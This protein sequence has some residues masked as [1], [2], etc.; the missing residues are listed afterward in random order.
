MSVSDQTPAKGALSGLRVLELGQLI[1]G[2]MA[3]A[4][5]G[6]YGAEVVKIEKPDGG[7]PIRSWRVIEDGT[8]VWW[9]HLARNKRLAAID[10][11]TEEG[12]ML[13]RELALVADV[14]IENFRPGTLEAWGLDPD[15][16]RAANPR[17]IVARVSGYGQTGPDR[18][19]RGFASVCEAMGGLRYVTGHPGEIPVRSNLSIGDSLAGFHTT[20]GILLALVRRER[21]AERRGQVVD[22]SIVE[23]VMSVMEG[24]I[25]EFDR[26][27]AVRQPSGTTITGVVPTGAYPCSDGR[28][29]VIG[30]NGDSM[31]RR[32]MRTMARDD[33]ADD[34]R[35]ATNDLRVVA[36][37]ELDEAI[38]AWT[39][40]LTCEDVVA[41]L[42]DAGVPAGAI[43]TAQDLAEDAHLA[44]RGTFEHVDVG[45]RPLK[46]AAPGPRLSE[47]PGRTTHAGR[48]LGADTDVVLRD[49]LAV[50]PA[51]LAA[52]REANVIA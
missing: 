19:R 42:Q 7:D 17:L 10:L 44:E 35:L 38:G 30:A 23:S 29:V 48:D 28:R 45:G 49:W 11:R 25:S 26:T 52:L 34:P 37:D 36:Q 32:L 13:V 4:L 1:A 39:S 2:P 46:L 8:S 15:D 9:R 47:T 41:R 6:W 40:T 18:E 51:R 14:L 24:A 50:E 31:F 21:D 22:V 33:L 3:G 16:L 43:R 20:M 12:R 5:L 27:G